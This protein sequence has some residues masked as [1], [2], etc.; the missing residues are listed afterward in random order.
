MV[1]EV[2]NLRAKHTQC[3]AKFK[4]FF[5]R[6]R[7]RL[8]VD[9]VIVQS[10]C[11][12]SPRTIEEPFGNGSAVECFKYLSTTNLT[13]VYRLIVLHIRCLVCKYKINKQ[14]LITQLFQHLFSLKFVSCVAF[15][16]R[17]DA[18]S[19]QVS[20]FGQRTDRRGAWRV[21]DVGLILW[22]ILTK[23]SGH[24]A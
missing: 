24:F 2:N 14:S 1:S 7:D 23:G 13:N 5:G 11:E 15:F 17:E 8:F 3:R 21:G 12:P 4:E 18:S 6:K 10:L 20:Y 16:R 19:P 9:Q 22:A